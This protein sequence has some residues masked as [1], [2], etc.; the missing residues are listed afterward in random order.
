MKGRELVGEELT[1]EGRRAPE[2]P[3]I[4][5]GGVETEEKKPLKGVTRGGE[6][7]ELIEA[8]SARRT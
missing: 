1:A 6:V 5:S 3:G 7:L 4:E 2:P 8:C